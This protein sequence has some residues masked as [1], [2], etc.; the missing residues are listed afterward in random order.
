[1]SSKVFAR[2]FFGRP[3]PG[4]RWALGFFMGIVLTVILA[5]GLLW[6]FSGV[7]LF[8]WVR[9]AFGSDR[10]LL[11]VSQPTV[12]RQIQRLERLET[13]RY[14]MEKIVEGERDRGVLPRF[15]VGDRML[16]IAYGEVSA[17]VD[18]G[19]VGR[20]QIT[21]SGRGVAVQLPPAEL[22]STRIDNAK[23]RVYSRS[24]GILVALDPSLETEVRREA[25]RQLRQAALEDGILEKARLNA[26]ETLISLLQGLG[27][28]KVEIR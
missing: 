18:L 4:T 10:T 5:G 27:F 25:E 13:V 24:T 21:V 28:E 2:D 22:F 11:N 14:T 15:L 20:E 23:T 12:V 8:S 26:T 1:M 9:G 3:S 19:R 6:S 7:G 17:G 16:L